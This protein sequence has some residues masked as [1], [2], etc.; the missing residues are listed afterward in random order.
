MWWQTVR[1]NW[2]ADSFTLHSLLLLPYI[3]FI[4]LFIEGEEDLWKIQMFSPENPFVIFQNVPYFQL[5]KVIFAFLTCIDLNDSSGILAL[6]NVQW[7]GKALTV[8]SYCEAIK[9]QHLHSE[10][11]E[12]SLE[13]CYIQLTGFL[14]F[15]IPEILIFVHWITNYTHAKVLQIYPQHFYQ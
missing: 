6:P 14:K 13:I 4:S 1:H 15:C 9:R 5:K 11:C 7:G 10:T 12:I 2:V 8:E 3:C